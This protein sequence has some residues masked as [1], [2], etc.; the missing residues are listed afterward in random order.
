MKSA[1]F[2]Y[3]CP[4]SVEEAISLLA[5]VADDEGR[6]LAGGQS[7]VPMMALRLA[8]PLHLIDINGIDSLDFLETDSEKIRIGA[9]T[10]HACFHQEVVSN[11]LGRLLKTTANHIAHY[12]I[13]Q[14]GTFCGSIAHADPASEWCLIAAA[15]DADMEVTGSDGTR[16]INASDFFQGTMT[17]AME[18]NEMLT[19]V[20][21][22]LLD[23]NDC[24]GFYEFNRRPGDFAIAMCLVTLGFEGEIVS[25]I[26]IAVGA[27]EDIPRRIHGAEEILRNNRATED[28]IAAAAE[29]AAD[30]ISPL[31]DMVISSAYRKHIVR[32]VVIRALKQ[33]LDSSSD[34]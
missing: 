14:R 10:R 7:L 18:A 22:P 19:A 32:I 29:A 24:F 28:N 15:I 20:Y 13:R 8:S 21:L 12:P 6:I 9:L 34:R 23:N 16:L 2:N 33:A 11:A 30:N 3:Y 17:T 31:T 1:P 4:S 26:R 27:A 5:D 25:R